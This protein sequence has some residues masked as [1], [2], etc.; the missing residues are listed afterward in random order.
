M[1]AKESGNDVAPPVPLK[2]KTG[3]YMALVFPDVNSDLLISVH[4]HVV[5]NI[6]STVY[7]NVDVVSF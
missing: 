1:K 2:K 6:L 5:Q 7:V 3:N 4:I